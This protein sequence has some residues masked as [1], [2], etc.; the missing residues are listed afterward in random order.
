VAFSDDDAL[1]TAFGTEQVVTDT[2]IATG[3][4]HWTSESSAVTIAGSPAANDLVVFRVRRA[5][6][7]GSDTLA[8]DARLIA[9]RL[10]I[11]TNDSID[12]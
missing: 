8:A 12:A 5:P 10:F 9:I 6:S 11:T 2:L 3:D 7:N 1:D 4:V